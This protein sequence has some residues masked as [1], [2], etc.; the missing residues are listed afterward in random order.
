MANTKTQK[1]LTISKQKSENILNWFVNDAH[2]KLLSEKLS[3]GKSSIFR[4][5]KSL[6][7][8]EAETDAFDA[9][10]QTFTL[11][12]LN[13]V[14]ELFNDYVEHPE[15]YEKPKTKKEINIE[16]QAEVVK[17]H[18]EEMNMDY[19]KPKGS[20]KSTDNNEGKSENHQ[21]TK[22]ILKKHAQ[23]AQKAR[24]EINKLHPDSEERKRKEA[25]F[26]AN[27]VDRI[28]EFWQSKRNNE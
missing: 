21:S 23:Q 28:K 24:E 10:A 26:E 3:A 5:K 11:K 25:E 27:K 1:Q 14:I 15:K 2:W 13:I 6:N 9:L 16:K 8:L 20:K 18:M 17:K 12:H 22:E 7:E 19:S 4:Y